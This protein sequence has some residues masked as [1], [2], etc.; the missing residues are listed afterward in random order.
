MRNEKNTENSSFWKKL[1]I[2]TYNSWVMSISE[3]KVLLNGLIPNCIGLILAILITRKLLIKLHDDQNWIIKPSF[4][5]QLF[6]TVSAV[7]Y[8]IS[9]TAW[10]ILYSLYI[11]QYIDNRTYFTIWPIADAFRVIGTS[12]YFFY[13][14]STLE[15][16]MTADTLFEKAISKDDSIFSFANAIIAEII[17]LYNRNNT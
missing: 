6:A 2:F 17:D 9:F 14:I 3:T 7:S 11:P 5:N 15:Y 8:V 12:S 16:Q 1:T 10:I 13:V 4:S